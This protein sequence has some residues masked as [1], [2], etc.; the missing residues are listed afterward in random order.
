VPISPTGR[1]AGL[2]FAV[3]LIV[4]GIAWIAGA[5]DEMLCMGERDVG[6]CFV[7]SG[8][9]G[10]IVFLSVGVVVWG[11]V[12]IRLMR[13]RPVLAEGSSS[14]TWGI[15]IL[16][17]AGIAVAATRLPQYDCPPGVPVDTDFGLCLGPG[18]HTIAPSWFWLKLLIAIVGLVLGLTVMRSRRHLGL[19]APLAVAAWAFGMGWLLLDTLA[20]EF[21]PG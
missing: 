1:A 7:L 18:G 2:T 17:A 11:I 3:C 16:F 12:L 5:Y 10:V 20:R 15:G 21:L 4:T 13:R 14:W 6:R 19:T 9:G 8:I